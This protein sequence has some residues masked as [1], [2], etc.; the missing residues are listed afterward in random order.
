M[1]M[2]SIAGS[3]PLVCAP[4]GARKAMIGHLQRCR[5]QQQQCAARLEPGAC[6]P[7]SSTEFAGPPSVLLRW[8]RIAVGA[9][10]PAADHAN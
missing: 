5:K 7:G 6:L 2:L 9:L 3:L 1:T 4:L 8:W 10:I